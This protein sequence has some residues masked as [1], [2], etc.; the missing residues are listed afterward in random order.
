MDLFELHA[1]HT[2][3]IAHRLD[4]TLMYAALRAFQR[5]APGPAKSAVIEAQLALDTL[6]AALYKLQYQAHIPAPDPH[7]E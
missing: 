5:P 4:D 3:E 7:D 1:D 6:M 2:V